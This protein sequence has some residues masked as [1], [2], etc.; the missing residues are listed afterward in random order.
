MEAPVPVHLVQAGPTGCTRQGSKA[1]LRM[2]GG[3]VQRGS[4]LC[5]PDPGPTAFSPGRW[6]QTALF[7]LETRLL[8]AGICV[9]P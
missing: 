2:E 7:N 8:G 4:Q 6:G 3:P 5:E 9:C 1:P